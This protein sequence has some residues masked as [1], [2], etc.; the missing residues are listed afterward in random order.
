MSTSIEWTDE[1]WNP[2]RGCKPVSPG[3]LNCYAKGQAHRFSGPGAPYEGL[4]QLRRKGHG[5]DWTGVFREV[6]D[7]L[8]AP[9][10]WNWCNHAWRHISK[11]WKRCTCCGIRRRR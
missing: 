1:T 6:P 3:C 11:C 10:H 4:T 5:A 8:D 9:F 7:M 2:V